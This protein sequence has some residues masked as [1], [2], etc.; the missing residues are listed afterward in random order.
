MVDDKVVKPVQRKGRSVIRVV[1]EP[2][3]KSIK[4]LGRKRSSKRR[5]KKRSNK[6]RSNSK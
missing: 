1:A 2:L 6:K 3:T 4:N 5:N